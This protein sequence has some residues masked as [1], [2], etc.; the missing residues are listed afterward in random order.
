MNW[1]FTGD[2]PVYQ[3]IMAA[4]EPMIIVFMAAIVGCIVGAVMLPMLSMYSAL[5]NL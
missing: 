2:R 3:Q 4:I 1:K 5:D